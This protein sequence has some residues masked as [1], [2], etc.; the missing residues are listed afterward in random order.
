M[1]V[2][3]LAPQPFYRLR[4]MC[5]AQRSILSALS[6]MGWRVDLLTFP[7]GEDVDIPG[8]RILRLP[9]L[10]WVRDVSI[11]PSWGKL[12]LD[13]LMPAYAFA[14]C[15]R[16]RYALVHACE[17]S[18]FLGAALKRLFGLPLL[19]DMDDILSLR[20]E[21]SGF[22]RRGALLSLVRSAEDWMLRSAD[23]VLT[24][25]P[26]T[27]SF[28]SARAAAGRVVSYDHAPSLPE[29]PTLGEAEREA[30]RDACNL[31]HQRV[32]LYAGNLEPYQGVDLLLESLPEVLRRSPQTCCVVVGGEPAQIEALRARARELGLGESVRWLGKRPIPETLRLMR[33]ADVL[34]SPMVQEKAVPMKLY[35]YMASGVPIVATDLPN[36][37]SLLDAGNAVLVRRDAGALA[38]GIL[39][40]LKDGK[41]AGRLGRQALLRLRSLGPD[42]AARRSVERVYGMLSR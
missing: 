31:D 5:I 38:E 14:L 34:V 7:F 27:T 11:G 36:H 23:A 22:F 8:V 10:P 2:L 41:E 3:F 16:N 4:G 15:L 6:Q 20:L 1:R 33:V 30:L 26:D 37:K 35:A 40:M 9:R 17:E 12:A 32:V 39:G 25:S 28:A 13:L 19:Y 42:D 21:R 29:E 24:N 18:A